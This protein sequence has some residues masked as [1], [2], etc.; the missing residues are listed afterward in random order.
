MQ[1]RRWAVAWSG[2]KSLTL[3]R[4]TSMWKVY[5]NRGERERKAGSLMGKREGKGTK[6]GE[7]FCP[8][9]GAL[10]QDTEQVPEGWATM[11]TFSACL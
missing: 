10:H 7:E 2:G 6:E 11:P 3:C 5:Y 4:H 1:T 8:L 9:K